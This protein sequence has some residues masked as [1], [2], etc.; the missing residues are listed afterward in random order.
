VKERSFKRLSIVYYSLV[1]SI[2]DFI[3]RHIVKGGTAWWFCIKF[4]RVAKQT[5]SVC[6]WRWNRTKRTELP[7]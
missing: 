7:M 6:W 5:G 4:V 1:Q 3:A 2:V